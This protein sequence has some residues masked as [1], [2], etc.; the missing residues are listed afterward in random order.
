M[1]NDDRFETIRTETTE[2]VRSIWLARPDALNTI[3]PALRDEL[4]AAIEAE[5][6]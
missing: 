6:G 2:R 1:S 3:T 4:A 5:L